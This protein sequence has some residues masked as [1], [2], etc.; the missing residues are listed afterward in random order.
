[1]S[2]CKQS[3]W[4]LALTLILP[5]CVE[6]TA[7]SAASRSGASS[8]D[9]AQWGSAFPS[10]RATMIDALQREVLRRG[11]TIDVCRDR[12]G[13][14]DSVA[15]TWTFKLVPLTEEEGPGT[16]SLF[17]AVNGGWP[18]ATTKTYA[19]GQLHYDGGPSN[20]HRDLGERLLGEIDEAFLADWCST[21]DKRSIESTK[22]VC[23]WVNHSRPPMVIYRQLLA[24]AD[25]TTEV[26]RYDVLLSDVPSSRVPHSMVLRFSDGTLVGWESPK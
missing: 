14:P 5:S 6:S 2:A 24:C 13:D 10:E 9:V 4:L 12:L 26:W 17:I 19:G 22:D 23:Y 1:V 11:M 25:E 15:S 3:G 8:L 20:P 16:Q 21:R 18:I 7:P